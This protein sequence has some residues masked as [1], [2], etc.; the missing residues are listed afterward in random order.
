MTDSFHIVCPQCSSVNR[1]LAHRLSDKP[2]CGHCKQALFTHQ[3]IELTAST[4]TRHISRNDIPV[5]VDFWAPWCGPCKM[6]AP[7]FHEAAGMLEPKVILAK[8]DTDAAQKS[9]GAFN[10]RG[11]PT[12]I[13]FQNGVEKARKSGAMNAAGIKSW[14]EANI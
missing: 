9:A 1:I 5:V 12:M 7:A 4:F 8:L 14:V 2:K 11:I 6:M 13:I 10:I 3:P